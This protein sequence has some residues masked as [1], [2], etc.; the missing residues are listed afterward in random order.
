MERRCLLL[1]SNKNFQYLKLIPSPHSVLIKKK[2][3]STTLS[4]WLKFVFTSRADCNLMLLFSAKYPKQNPSY[5]GCHSIQQLIEIH[6]FT[7][8]SPMLYKYFH[9]FA[10]GKFMVPFQLWRYCFFF[11]NVAKVTKFPS[12]YGPCPF[13]RHSIQII[14]N[15]S[16]WVRDGL[17]ILLLKR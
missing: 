4:I 13:V 9:Y 1:T 5:L 10:K 15:F 7:Q 12:Q 11:F 14:S 17:E 6:C 2:N 8:K 16:K 3:I